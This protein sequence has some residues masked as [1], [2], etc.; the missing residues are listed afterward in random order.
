MDQKK[1]DGQLV[2]V[3]TAIASCGFGIAIGASTS[4]NPG[5]NFIDI[6]DR[7]GPTLTS[8]LAIIAAFWAGRKAWQGVQE[9]ILASERQISEDKREKSVNI[10]DA[11]TFELGVT[12]AFL[13]AVPK[14]GPINPGPLG[15]I[16]ERFRVDLFATSHDAAFATYMFHNEL[17]DFIENYMARRDIGKVYVGNSRDLGCMAA[18]IAIAV[19]NTC[20]D[21]EKGIAIRKPLIGE[22]ELNSF[23]SKYQF[24]PREVPILSGLL[25]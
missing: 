22:K 17:K 21:I 9:Q 5:A 24:D 25:E 15:E 6:V 4:A 7:L 8:C 18:F 11:V 19:N 16:I 13:H 10:L 23:I 20:K 2:L 14:T 12:S 3:A 1:N